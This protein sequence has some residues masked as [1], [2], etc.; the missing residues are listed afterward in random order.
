MDV[1]QTKINKNQIM[2]TFKNLIIVVV[3]IMII[4][5]Q[6]TKDL[7]LNSNLPKI[8]SNL[9]GQFGN[10]ATE[11]NLGVFHRP[12]NK[13]YFALLTNSPS[14]DFKIISGVYEGIATKSKIDLNHKFVVDYLGEQ[15]EL[16]ATSPDDGFYEV[17]GLYSETFLKQKEI[18]EL[19]NS[20]RLKHL[21]VN[22]FKDGNL[23]HVEEL[24]IPKPVVFENLSY[25]YDKYASLSILSKSDPV[26]YYEVDSDNEHGI[27]LTVA[28][29][30]SLV[31]ES[32]DEMLDRENRSTIT[33]NGFYEKETGSLRIPEDV[34]DNI[35]TNAEIMIG[36][37]R[38]SANHFE[39]LEAKNTAEQPNLIHFM[40]S[41][42]QSI[43]AV[44]VE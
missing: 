8:S 43:G 4:S 11:S 17:E 32:Y 25:D 38:N 29:T 9:N 39:D 33:W 14:R 3:A 30:G 24:K 2:T 23:K 28:W 27:L 20:G 31:G 16:Y 22:Y 15:I 37:K 26:V 44:L 36:I 40:I 21:K 7:T 19:I 1:H 10:D 42:A 34:I 12:F 6:S 18:S 13:G 35:P 5:C 41:E